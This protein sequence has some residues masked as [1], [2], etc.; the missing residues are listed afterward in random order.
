MSISFDYSGK[1]ILVTGGSRGIGLGIAQAFAKADADV[2]I[3]GTRPDA[4]GYDE[5]LSAFTYHQTR[6]TEQSDLDKLDA[7]LAHLDVLVNNAGMLGD[8]NAEFEMEGFHKTMDV[9][10]NAVADLCYRFKARLTETRGAMINVASVAGILGIRNYPAYTA[11][12]HAV[13]GL[14]KSLADKWAKTGMRINV[15]APGYI[16]T[17]MTDWAREDPMKEKGY[18]AGIP[19]GRFGKP[20]EIAVA[21]LFLAAP[22]ASYVCGHTLVVDGGLVVR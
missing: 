13:I 1:T 14:T 16:E 12:K 7:A 20:E 3:T 22:E 19:M 5:D 21:V 9:N 11:S 15:V 10:L 4:S 2:H 17:R 8:E 6:L 18:T